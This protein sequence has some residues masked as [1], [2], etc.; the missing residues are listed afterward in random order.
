MSNQTEQFSNL[1]SNWRKVPNNKIINIL[2]IYS[3][4]FLNLLLKL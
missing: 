1:Y 3:F 4:I 2:S